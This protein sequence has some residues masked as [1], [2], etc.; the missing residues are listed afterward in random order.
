[1]HASGTVLDSKVLDNH[2]YLEAD[3]P[4]SLARR[5]EDFAIPDSPLAGPPSRSKEAKV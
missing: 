2:M 4:E 1:V 5:L 3:L